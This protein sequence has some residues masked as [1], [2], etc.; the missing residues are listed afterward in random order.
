MRRVTLDVRGTPRPQGSLRFHK[1]ANGATAARYPANVYEWRS[2]VQQAVAEADVEPFEGAVHLA[3]G[4]DL[5]RPLGH[6]GTGRN[7]TLVKASAPPFPT[8]APDLDKLIRC[9]A[10]AV[11]DAGLW[12]DDAQVAAVTAAKRYAIHRPPGVLITVS[13]MP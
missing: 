6:F 4:F 10:D 5:A 1:L 7:K 13:E 3:L 12:K 8:V 11:T 9:I 2:Q